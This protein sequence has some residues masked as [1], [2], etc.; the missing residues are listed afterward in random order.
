MTSRHMW[1]VVCDDVRSE[2]GN[3]HSYIGVFSGDIIVPSFPTTLSK[4][5]A[6][7]NVRTVTDDPLTKLIF[8]ILQ[9]EAEL[10]RVEIPPE[11][12]DVV[13]KQ[14]SDEPQYATVS[15]VCQF[16]PLT[17]SNPCKLAFRADTEREE[18]K[19]GTVKVRAMTSTLRPQP[20]TVTDSTR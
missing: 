9:D 1:A 4:L 11:Q 18:L 13:M 8:R 5:C 19:G 6:I 12:L 10:V 20:V 16:S 2:V 7:M 17:F 15:A 14:K 3:K